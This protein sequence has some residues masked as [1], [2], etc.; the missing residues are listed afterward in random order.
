MFEPRTSASKKI[1]GLV[2]STQIRIFAHGGLVIGNTRFSSPARFPVNGTHLAH[3]LRE[4]ARQP[5]SNS[6]GPGLVQSANRGV[7][8]DE[9]SRSWLERD[10]RSW[11]ERDQGGKSWRNPKGGI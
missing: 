6:F 4:E 11:L 8:C 2:P 9:S 3:E 1:L 5:W 10:R 7:F